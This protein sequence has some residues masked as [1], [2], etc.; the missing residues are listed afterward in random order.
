MR[1]GTANSKIGRVSG[2]FLRVFGCFD[3]SFLL[4]SLENCAF[5]LFLVGKLCFFVLNVFYLLLF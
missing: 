4:F 3:V 1:I 2:R 5:L